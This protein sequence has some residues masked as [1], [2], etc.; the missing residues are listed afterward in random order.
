MT[1]EEKKDIEWEY[2]VR[3]FAFGDRA[4]GTGICRPK[5]R[6]LS[7]VSAGI[8]AG[9]GTESESGSRKR[10]RERRRGKPCHR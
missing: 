10:R 9:A 7:K 3:E 1:D 6:R 2:R 4:Y 8:R 5:S